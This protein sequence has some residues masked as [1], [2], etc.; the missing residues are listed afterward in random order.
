[1]EVFGDYAL[2]GKLA[3]SSTKSMHGHA[4]GAAGGIEAIACIMAMQENIVPPTINLDNLDEEIP[5]ELNLVPNKAQKKE[6]NVV[7]SNS[8]GFGGQN[9][10]LIFKRFE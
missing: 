1:L 8:F 3:I 7:M 6:L 5:K 10:S 9:V 4:L 2:S